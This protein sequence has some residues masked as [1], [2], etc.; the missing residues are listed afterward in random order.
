MNSAL[1]ETFKLWLTA[2][3]FTVPLFTGFTGVKQPTNDQTI[4]IFVS[5]AERAASV[6]YRAT[7]NLMIATP[8][9]DDGDAT[10][11]LGNHR[12]TVEAVRGLLE[13]PPVALKT[14]IEANS[15]LYYRGGWMTDGGENS[16]D[17]GRW[18]TTIEFMAGIS[19]SAAS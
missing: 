10:L 8:P 11:A 14:T 12:A 19:T 7:V 1:E 6:L 16:I 17:G 5:D 18:V 3:G 2:E 15:A 9:H 4:T 13:D